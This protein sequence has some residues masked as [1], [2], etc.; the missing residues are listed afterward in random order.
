[1]DRDKI[2]LVAYNAGATMTQI[3]QWA[4]VPYS[5]VYRALRALPGFQPRARGARRT[6]P[7]GA[8][9]ETIR[10]FAVTGSVSATA[11][12]LQTTPTTV[13]KRL[14]VGSEVK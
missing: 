14:N 8:Q 2:W 11:Y 1:M 7:V 3:A 6:A 10:V 13:R 9:L 5:V 4:A 12:E